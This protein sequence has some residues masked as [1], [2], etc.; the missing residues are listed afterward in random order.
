MLWLLLVL[1]TATAGLTIRFAPLGLPVWL[2]KYGGSVLWAVLIY[3]IV[4]GVFGRVRPG[5][6]GA[7]AF[8]FATAVELFKLHSSPSLDR[9][10]Q[11]LA[12]MLLLGRFFSVWDICAYAVGIVLAAALDMRLRKIA[13]A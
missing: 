2:R 1:S 12:G 8:A 7:I 6:T 3:W 10:R 13:G 9:F 11:T 4:S 5:A